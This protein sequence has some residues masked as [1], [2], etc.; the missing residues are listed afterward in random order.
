VAV[1]EWKNGIGSTW[2]GLE[3]SELNWI[4]KYINSLYWVSIKNNHN[5]IHILFLIKDCNNNDHSWIWRYW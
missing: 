1:L 5:F 2:L 3:N 4:E